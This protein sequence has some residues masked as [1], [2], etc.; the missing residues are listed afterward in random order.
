MNRQKLH[1]IYRYCI[2]WLYPNICPVCEKLIDYNADFCDDCKSRISLYSDTYDIKYTD[3]FAA[4]CVYDHNI[5]N[6]L[7]KFKKDDCGNSYY[8]FAV[9]IAEAIKERGIADKI[10]M[11]VPIPITGKKMKERGYNQTELIAKELRFLIDKPYKNVLC[12]IKDTKDQKSLVGQER[13]DNVSGVF[14]IAEKAPDI[15]GMSLLVI[16][17]ICTTGSTLSEAAKVL[18]ENGAYAV[19][20]ASY[21]KTELKR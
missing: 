8:A 12:K 5:D 20:A 13:A 9:G 21:A 19:Y 18:K 7:L 2:D 11:I 4:Y 15:K 14:G 10:E 1:N 16:D 17:D 3:G 6:A